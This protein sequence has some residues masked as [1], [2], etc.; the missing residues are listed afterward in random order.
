MAILST[1]NQPSYTRLLQKGIAFFQFMLVIY[2]L[3]G[4][5]RDHDNMITL[6]L[7]IKLPQ[8]SLLPTKTGNYISPAA[9]MTIPGHLCYLRLQVNLLGWGGV[10]LTRIVGLVSVQLANICQLELSLAKIQIFRQRI[11]CLQVLAIDSITCSNA[12]G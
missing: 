7:L 11:T 9:N 2:T 1:R 10:G 8:H 12:N 6:A 4:W 3:V 5:F